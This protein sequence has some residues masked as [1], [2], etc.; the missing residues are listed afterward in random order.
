MST[1]HAVVIGGSIAGLSAAQALRSRFDKVTILEQDAL[2]DRPQGRRGTPQAWHNHFLLDRGRQSLDS[3]F[4]GFTDHVVAQ[5]GTLLDPAYDAVQCLAT[6]WVPRSQSGMRMLFAS[7]PNFES[8]IRDLARQDPNI[9]FVENAPV[10]GLITSSE[11]SGVRVTGVNYLDP[12]ER[13]T[14]D[15]AADLVVDASGRGSKCAKW[16]TDL[17]VDIEERTLDAQVTYSSRWYR[18]P[19]QDVSW[20]KWLTVLPSID[21]DATDQQRYLC[22]IFPIE[23]NSFI[24]VMGSWGLPMP[25]TVDDFEAAY[26]TTRSPEFGRVLDAAEPLTDVHRTKSTK[27]VW[28]RFD[29]AANLPAGYIAV[30]DA[31]CAFNPIYAQGMTCAA[32]SGVILRDLLTRRDFHDHS[33]PV[34]F[35]GEQAKLLDLPWQLA[36]T[37]DGAYD[38]ATGTDVMSNG[39]MRKLVSR[40]TWSGFQ[41]MTEAA[42]EDD[43]INDHFDKV[44]NLHESLGEFLRNP[45]V[46]YGLLRYGVRKILGRSSLPKL[47]APHLE[48]DATDVTHLRGGAASAEVAAVAR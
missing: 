5:G 27:N 37:R 40:Y 33:F 39:L 19:D 6:G 8:C 32:T 15:L 28:R 46:L 41:F 48:P 45:R 2:P 11:P 30:G 16:M 17:G 31:V 22:S 47:V 9:R 20:W 42:F 13:A 4:P 35:Y 25:S 26:R 12:A 24:A 10:S 7:R 34:A 23:D 29:K 36:L 3:L 38:H 18:W 14:R 1:Q 21:P 43:V 44:F